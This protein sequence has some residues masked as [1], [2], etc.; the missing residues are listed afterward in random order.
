MKEKILK[1]IGSIPPESL[2]NYIKQGIV[3]YQELLVH[4]LDNYPEKRSYLESKLSAGEQSAWRDAEQTNTVDAYDMYLSLFAN[5]SHSQEARDAIARLEDEYWNHIQQNMS[6]QCLDTYERIYP[7]GKYIAECAALKS[8]LPWL[9][10]KKR[11]TKDA[12]TTYGANYPGQHVEEIRQAIDAIEDVNDWQHAAQLNTRPAYEEYLRKHPKGQYASKAKERLNNRTQ[13]EIVLDAIRKDDNSYSASA[14]QRVVENGTISWDDLKEVFTESQ[15]QAIKEWRDIPELPQC[16]PPQTLRKDSTEIY[17]WGTKKTGKTC[18][19]G[20]VLSAAKKDGLMIARSCQHRI[21]MDQLSNLFG[22]NSMQTI[23]SLPGSTSKDSIAE[24]N[25]QFFDSKKKKHNVTFIDLAGEV[26]TGIYKIRNNIILTDSERNTVNQ[27][28]SYLRNPYNNK[29]HFFVLEYGSA[30]REVKEL[31]DME[32]PNIRQADVLASIAE[33][34]QEEKVLK[35]STVGVYGLVSKS[36]LI[37]SI[38][39]TNRD[40]RPH[41]ASEYVKQNLSAFWNA[42]TAASDEAK[43]RDVKTISFSIGDVFAE[44][45]CVFDGNDS[46][47][48]IDRLLL[49]TKP[50]PEGFF[51]WLFR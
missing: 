24:M 8:D 6:E 17:F 2:Y 40:E 34:L 47:K 13:K 49:K 30:D 21:Y 15:V 26:V 12:Y 42:I 27:V 7:N 28:L 38:Q 44:K 33:F 5:G 36:D 11:N 31:R 20:A 16:V 9:E 3:T 48:I 1:A 35:T 43:V 25:L 22:T 46:R 4:G 45:L 39:G 29:I 41:L 32:I 14:L 10:A 51:G 37:D 18:A 23:C 19:M 50:E